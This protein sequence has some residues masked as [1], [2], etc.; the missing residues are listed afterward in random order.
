VRLKVDQ[1]SLPHL[2]PTFK[3]SAW[4]L[5][6]ALEFKENL[7][8][9]SLC[10]LRRVLRLDDSYGFLCLTAETNQTV[11]GSWKLETLLLPARR[12]FLDYHSI[13]WA[14]FYVV[15]CPNIE[16]KAAISALFI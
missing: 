6:G 12:N 15:C 11:N 3:R 4:Q 13:F 5:H 16:L 10:G 2:T 8:E 1:L 9:F 7:R 14:T